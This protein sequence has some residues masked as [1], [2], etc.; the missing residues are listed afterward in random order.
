MSRLSE[1]L[2]KH[3][4]KKLNRN[5]IRNL[6]QKIQIFWAFNVLSDKV[7]IA[8][9]PNIN[10]PIIFKGK[11]EIKF[12]NNANFGGDASPDFYSYSYIEARN[13]NTEIEFGENFFSNNKLT[14]IAEGEGEEGGVK[15]GKDVI[16]GYRVSIV[17][18]N[19]HDINPQ[20][21]WCNKTKGA[22][23]KTGKVII[24][25]NVWVGSDS[26]I[27]K[28]VHI[29]KNSIIAAGSIVTKSIPENVIAGGNPAKIIRNI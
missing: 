20:K 26:I 28:G 5:N 1:W 11:G 8:G 13:S 7:E 21:R 6:F 17:D 3:K 18:S 14:I 25:D 9:K 29:G 23:I 27:L 19:F 16:F 15:I 2:R 24:D 12:S 22:N 10:N 4:P